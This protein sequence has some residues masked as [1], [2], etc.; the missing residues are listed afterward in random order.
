MGV[1]QVLV[2]VVLRGQAFPTLWTDEDSRTTEK[3]LCKKRGKRHKFVQTGTAA[4]HLNFAQLNITISTEPQP[5][6]L[7][8][9][10]NTS[11]AVI[12]PVHRN[13]YVAAR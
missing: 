4:L 13:V 2:E 1:L 9:Y 12:A 8:H 5:L 10:H 6:E 11:V 7:Q 3:S